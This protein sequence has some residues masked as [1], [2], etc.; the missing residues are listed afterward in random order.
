MIRIIIS[1]IIVFFLSVSSASAQLVNPLASQNFQE[2]LDRIINGL[3]WIG[4]A[5][6]PMFVLIA[7]F[8]LLTAAGNPAQIERGKRIIVYT[9]VGILV[10]IMAKGMVAFLF[11]IF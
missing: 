9:L 4:L 6:A 11:N 1:S 10:I 8:Y 3:S 5:L 7:A 2:L